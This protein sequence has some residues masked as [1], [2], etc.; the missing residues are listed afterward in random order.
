VYADRARLCRFVL[1]IPYP[2]WKALE[3]Y[4]FLKKILIMRM[5]PQ[6]EGYYGP[7][8]SLNGFK[9]GSKLI[10]RSTKEVCWYMDLL[11]LSSRL[12]VTPFYASTL[13]AFGTCGGKIPRCCP[14]FSLS[15][16][17]P[18]CCVQGLSLVGS[19]GHISRVLVMW[20]LEDRPGC[21]PSLQTYSESDSESKTT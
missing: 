11:F 12:C 4:L 8:R 7:F 2:C 1:C 5:Y 20:G 13:P 3:Y 19:S 14:I 15:F 9:G 18:A 17:S 10:C 6:W 16:H 21:E